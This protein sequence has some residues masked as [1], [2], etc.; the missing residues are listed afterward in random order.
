MGSAWAPVMMKI[1]VI[2]I[3][4]YMLYPKWIKHMNSNMIMLLNNIPEDATISTCEGHNCI[5]L[6]STT[7]AHR[8]SR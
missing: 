3:L 4:A 5:A 2:V 1:A 8:S 6:S 7:W